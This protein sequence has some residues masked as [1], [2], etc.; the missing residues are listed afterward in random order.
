MYAGRNEA[1]I[2]CDLNFCKIRLAKLSKWG[3]PQHIESAAS[4]SFLCHLIF[5]P[6]LVSLVLCNSSQWREDTLHF[7]IASL[8]AATMSAAAPSNGHSDG[9]GSS[10]VCYDT[11][12][13]FLKSP[14]ILLVY[15]QITNVSPKITD[16]CLVIFQ[17]MHTKSPCRLGK[18]TPFV[19]PI[20]N[21]SSHIKGV[22]SAYRR[23]QTQAMSKI[24]LGRNFNSS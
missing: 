14:L 13:Q 1:V 22:E 21:P 16:L 18:T 7:D 17:M 12:S 20:P 23:V 5:S 8:Y 9:G 4:F 3:G 6:M 11:C 15:R 10:A 2:G 19:N 24:Y